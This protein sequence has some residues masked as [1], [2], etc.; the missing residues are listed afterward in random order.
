VR[1]WD[2]ELEGVAILIALPE[3]PDVVTDHALARDLRGAALLLVPAD[4]TADTVL[5][6]VEE[7]IGSPEPPGFIGSRD[8]HDAMDPVYGEEDFGT[9][10]R[11]REEW[12][13]AMKRAGVDD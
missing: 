4:T 8:S 12:L 2:G 13:D 5:E 6:R 1:R 11:T 10:P 3:S 9:G 7:A